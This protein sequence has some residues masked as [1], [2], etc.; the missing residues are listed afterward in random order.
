MII[1]KTLRTYFCTIA[2]LFTFFL[3]QSVYAAP[4]T[5]FAGNIFDS[6]NDGIVERINI[7]FTSGFTSTD[8]SADEI[9]SDWTYNGGSIGGSL[10]T[11]TVQG[12]TIINFTIIGANEGVTSGVMPTI[13]YN[14]NDGDNSIL[15]LD[16]AMGSVGP[17]TLNDGAAPA[18]DTLSPLDNASDVAVDTNFSIIFTEIVNVENGN[19]SI[20]KSFDDTLVEIIDVTSDLVTGSGTNTITIDP[21]NDLVQNTGY[22][23]QI[24][25]FSFSDESINGVPGL[26][27]TTAWNFSTEGNPHNL[28]PVQT[29]PRIIYDDNATYTFTISGPGDYA[30]FSE[31]CG[32]TSEVTINDEGE[33]KEFILTNLTVGETYECNFGVQSIS[34]SPG[35]TVGPFTVGRRPRSGSSVQYGCKDESATNYEYFSRHKQE[36][37]KYSTQTDMT[38]TSI[39]EIQNDTQQTSGGQLSENQQSNRIIQSIRDLE[40]GMQGPDVKMLQILL[41]NQGYSIPAGPT[42]Y[43]G[44]QTQYALDAYQVTNNI[45]PRGGYFGPITRAQ[46][47]STGLEG[48]WW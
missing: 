19:I 13:S 22:Y 11:A 33:V 3:S 23:I 14:N 46:M 45:A 18:I 43:F 25:E 44:K 37:C 48:L 8:L 7:V 32:G 9:A 30:Y 38:Q 29:I 36:L 40:Y 27:D 41:I 39:E 15:N 28:T 20:Y 1:Y 5:F 17:I 24:E 21:I 26:S 16:G 35:L 12:S 10:G 34:G 47:K 42:D 4:P 31:I 2:L 6:D